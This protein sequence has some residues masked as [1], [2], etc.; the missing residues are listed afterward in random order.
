MDGS[1]RILP[2]EWAVLNSRLGTL[3]SAMHDDLVLV[4][5]GNTRTRFAAVESGKGAEPRLEPSQI[6]T[7]DDPAAIARAI[8]AATGGTE[9]P[10]GARIVIASVNQPSADAIEAAL[11][12]LPDADRVL[13]FGRDLAIPIVHSLDEEAAKT[14][15]QDRLL[16]ALGAFARSEQACIVIDAGT[17]VTVDFVD[18][19]GTFHGG[20]IAPGVQMQLRALHEQTSAL[21]LVTMS[22]ELLPVTASDEDAGETPAPRPFGKNT[23]EAIARG[24]AGSIR[25]LAHDLIDRYA[26]FYGAYPRVV[27]TGGD[28]PLL[29]ENDPL[30]E[31]I[32]PDL[33]LIGMLE[34]VKRLDQMAGSEKDEE[35]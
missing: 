2:G 33:T 10:G 24:V 12:D 22:R 13:R 27:A 5:V 14:V 6:L 21:P 30:I 8:V 23:T 31:A 18:G 4:S 9:A 3:N 1:V 20:V 28:A 32:V 25:G 16:D 15:G 34:A 17:A 29:F 11:A 7:N 26:E 35:A 19:E